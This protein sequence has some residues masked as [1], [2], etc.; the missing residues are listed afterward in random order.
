VFIDATLIRIVLVPA[1]MQL[2]GDRN[3]WLP[4]WLDRL[5]PRINLSEETVAPATVAQPER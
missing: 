2:L 1:A 5:L 3:W 4:A